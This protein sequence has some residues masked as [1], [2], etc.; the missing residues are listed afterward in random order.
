MKELNTYLLKIKQRL[1][2]KTK[3][4]ETIRDVINSK[5]SVSLETQSFDI[6][7]GIIYV[8]ASSVIKSQ[9]FLEKEKIIKEL[10]GLGFRD[11]TNLQ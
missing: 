6:K 9:I 2:N 7:N 5:S 10:H 8:R 1:L 3:K 4:N 11:I